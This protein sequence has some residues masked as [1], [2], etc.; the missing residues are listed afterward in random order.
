MDPTDEKV[1]QP[2]E[3]PAAQPGDPAPSVS[4]A[5]AAT[6]EPDSTV[7]DAAPGGDPT[8]T[9]QDRLRALQDQ[10]R[11]ERDQAGKRREQEQRHRR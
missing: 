11:R 9:E 7:P 8:S 5:T 1:E 4:G 2:A 3:E 6:R 10:L